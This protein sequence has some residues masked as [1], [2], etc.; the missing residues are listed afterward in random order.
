MTITAFRR[1]TRSSFALERRHE[2]VAAAA[3]RLTAGEDPNLERTE[4]DR[5]AFFAL[6][7][8]IGAAVERDG[9]LTPESLRAAILTDRA[10]LPYPQ[11]RPVAAA[12]AVERLDFA[13]D[14]VLSE[15]ILAA[16]ERGE[17][18]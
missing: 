9:G 17:P 10:W 13:A 11:D 4:F 12:V 2:A 18:Q 1:R 3:A 16:W 7:L 15:A 5:G 8:L 14:V 6:G